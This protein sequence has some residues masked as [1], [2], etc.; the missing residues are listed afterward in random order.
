[1]ILPHAHCT[2]S[3][4]GGTWHQVRSSASPV[5]ASPPRWPGSTIACHYGI[6][7]PSP[8]RLDELLPF[9]AEALA[10]SVVETKPT[11]VM[12]RMRRETQP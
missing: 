12:H 7:L 3:A 10:A 8:R 2:K 1:M 11:T 6:S 5:H 9:L 4:R